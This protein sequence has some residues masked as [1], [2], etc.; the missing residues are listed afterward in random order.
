PIS[1]GSSF[2][3]FVGNLEAG[4]AAGNYEVEA[5]A[6]TGVISLI[7][8]DFG[9]AAPTISGVPQNGAGSTGT[10][11]TTS[12]TL[13]NGTAGSLRDD[14][15]LTIAGADAA[16]ELTSGMNAAAIKSALQAD[17]GLDALYTVAVDAT[18]L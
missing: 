18:T 11:T 12:F 8:K 1:T 3:E 14:Q 13:A 6:D 15:E 16:I 9:A 10:P 7:S 4:A 17:E 2:E 5:D